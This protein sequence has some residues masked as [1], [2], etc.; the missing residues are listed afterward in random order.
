MTERFRRFA[1]LQII[2]VLGERPPRIVQ[3]AADEEDR[4]FLPTE[5]PARM[6]NVDPGN[7]V[8]GILALLMQALH[9]AVAAGFVAHSNY[10]EDP[11]GRLMRT[12]TFLR[13]VT[14]GSESMAMRRVADVRQL[15]SAVHGVNWAGI[16]YDAEDPSLLEWVF[17]CFVYGFAK[18]YITFGSKTVDVGTVDAYVRDMSRIGSAFDVPSAP[19]TLLELQQRVDTL[20]TDIAPSTESVEL[21]AY[22]RSP[23]ALGR[24]GRLENS[25]VMRSASSLFPRSLQKQARTVGIPTGRQFAACACTNSMLK[26]VRWAFGADPNLNETDLGT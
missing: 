11:F 26:L 8:G 4:S 16:P 10:R 5:S 9:P 25:L 20:A 23:S 22:L 1:Q 7:I 18:G 12:S 19:S 24:F 17:L 15:H 14:F 13:E 2:K 6:F 3:P 21:V